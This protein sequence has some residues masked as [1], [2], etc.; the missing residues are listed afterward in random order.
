MLNETSS[1]CTAGSPPGNFAVPN[2]R[3]STGAENVA[4]PTSYL[5]RTVGSVGIRIYMGGL[6]VGLKV[7][8][9]VSTLTPP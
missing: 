5:S 9:F 8:I 2:V 6:V 1:R 4:N 7:G 3:G